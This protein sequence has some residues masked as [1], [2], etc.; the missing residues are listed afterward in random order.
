VLKSVRKEVLKG[1]RVVFISGKIST[2][3]LRLRKMAEELGAEWCDET[4][5]CVT[6][7]KKF[8]VNPNWIAAPNHMCQKQPEENFPVRPPTKNFFSLI[9]LV[10]RDP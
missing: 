2:Y 10:F 7:V 9:F 5:A 8:L 3:S 4:E 1:C 6:H